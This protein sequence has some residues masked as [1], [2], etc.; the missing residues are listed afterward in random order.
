MEENKQE[1]FCAENAPE[2]QQKSLEAQKFERR[3][4][5]KID[6]RYE[7]VPVLWSLSRFSDELAKMVEC[8]F[9]C[10]FT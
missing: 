3:L 4:V 9:S 8:L 10:S 7:N 6:A 5:R 2:E 1:V